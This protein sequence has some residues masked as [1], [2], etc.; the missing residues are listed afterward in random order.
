MFSKTCEYGIKATS[1]IA[2]QSQLGKRVSL[3]DIAAAIDS[4]TAFTAKILQQLSKVGIIHSIKGPNGG[5]EIPEHLLDKLC[6]SDVVVAI[7][8]KS[9]FV[10]CGLGLK[11]CNED[12]PCPVHNQFKLVR[13]SLRQM[14][15]TTSIRDLSNGL[16]EGLTHLKI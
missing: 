9:I 2:Y 14:L 8:G 1:H 4:P 6:L 15:E 13:A 16:H 10:E 3:K 7:D 12:K 11:A 5:F